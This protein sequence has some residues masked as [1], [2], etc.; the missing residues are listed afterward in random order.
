M[1]ELTLANEA[2]H[3][4]NNELRSK[5]TALQQQ[6]TPYGPIPSNLSYFPAMYYTPHE[7]AHAS[8]NNRQPNNIH[9]TEHAAPIPYISPIRLMPSILSLYDTAAQEQSRASLATRPLLL[10]QQAQY[11]RTKNPNYFKFSPLPVAPPLSGEQPSY[12]NHLRTV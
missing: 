3:S 5:L 6:Q 11:A 12:E 7:Q 8:Q 1:E 2:M 4:K 10:P 9:E